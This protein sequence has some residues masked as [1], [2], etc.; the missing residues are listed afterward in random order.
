MAK[1]SP[2]IRKRSEQSS[3]E[4]FGDG[5][6]LSMPNRQSACPC[7]RYDWYE[8]HAPNVD[9]FEAHVRLPNAM[10]YQI[11]LLGSLARS[12]DQ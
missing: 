2:S 11:G 12:I 7:H 10:N 4:R 8:R 3:G 9:A 1:M 5:S 6:S